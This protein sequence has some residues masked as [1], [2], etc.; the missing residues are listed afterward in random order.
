MSIRARSLAIVFAL[1]LAAPGAAA[2]AESWRSAQPPAPPPPEGQTGVG[3]PVALGNIGEISFWAP[4]HGLLITSGTDVVPAGL[5]YYNG[6]SWRELSTVCGGS[7]G[8]IAWVGENNFWTISNQQAGQQGV[9]EVEGEDRSLCHFENGVVVA[10]YAEPIGLADSYQQM[11]AAACL[12]PNDCWFAGEVLPPGL[13]SGAFH[14]HWNG[15]TLTTLP[16]LETPEPQ[17]EDL[18]QP[19]ASLAFY[20]GRLYESVRHES[21]AAGESPTQP[22]LIHKIVEGSS[23]PFVPMIVEGPPGEAFVYRDDAP[24]QLS[25]DSS[26]LWAISTGAP[27]PATVLLLNAS[28]QFQQVKLEDSEGALE[29]ETVAGV[30]AEPG[31][32]DAWVSLD[33]TGGPESSGDAQTRVTRIHA[34]GSVDPVDLLPEAGETL[35]RKGVARAIACP[36]ENDCWVASSQGW[37]F[38]LGGDYPEDN[39]PYFES[40]ITSRPADASIPFVAP[41]SFP[42]DD[43]G[44][45]PPS[46]PAPAAETSPAT[47]EVKVRAA[48]F[49]HVKAKLVDRTTLA[50]TFTLATKS[51]VKL[52]ALRKKR[53]VAATKRFVLAYG[54]HTL[55][56]RLDLRAW[57]TKLD[58]QVQAIGAVPLVSSSSKETES[59]G[60]PTVVTTSLHVFD[61]PL[62]PLTILP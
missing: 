6:V 61:R 8:R 37:L 34:D 11:D 59:T 9:S 23:K 20:K 29:G 49:S 14:L 58:L 62:S 25:A 40:L 15:Q 48:L 16:S 24:F 52:I 55:K 32:E 56:L 4:N 21:T 2:R 51:H 30:A 19:V 27:P 54:R 42:E 17:L 12:G 13:N 7:D 50:L 10:S 35:G 1:A 39:D 43:S 36:A 3:V 28:G 60:G 22:Y 33:P 53:R 38:H 57:P 45:N 47:S 46:I 41:E 44:A 31:T 5:Y 26:A 18:E